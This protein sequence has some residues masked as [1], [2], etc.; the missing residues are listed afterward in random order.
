MKKIIGGLRFP[1][2]PRWHNGEFWFSD[3]HGNSIMKASFGGDPVDDPTGDPL[4][5]EPQEPELTQ[6]V[7]F[8]EDFPS[9]LG[10]LQNGDLLIVAMESRK[11]Y[12]YDGEQLSPY[13]DLSDMPEGDINDMVVSENGNAYIG[14]M[15]YSIQAHNHLSRRSAELYRVSA[16][17]E[18]SIAAE[19]MEAPNGPALTPDEKTLIVAESAASRLTAFDVDSQTGELSNRRVF[20]Q[21]E[22]AAAADG[23]P[24][25]AAPPDGICLDAEGAAW[26]AEPLGRRVIRVKEG[27]EVTHTYDFEETIPF[28]C[29]QGGQDRKTLLIC[30]AADY[31]RDVLMQDFTGAIYA[32]KTEIPGAGKP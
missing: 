22:P 8:A 15:G 32:E 5:Q 17:G 13:A 27:G 25:R 9:G 6:V 29:V 18:V 19:N 30:T 2:G 1:E 7:P 28:A 14:N 20:A 23:S 11:L 12:K 3:M 31:K 16:E 26:V 10:W 21:L 4:T 24:L